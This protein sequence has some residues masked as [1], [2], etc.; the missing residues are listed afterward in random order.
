M[1]QPAF[2]KKQQITFNSEEEYYEFLGFL[3][4]ND[5]TTKLVWEENNEQGAWTEEGRILFFVNQPATLRANL[6]HTAGNYNI[7]FRVN[8]NDFIEDIRTNHSFVL[9]ETQN[10]AIIRNTIPNQF[11]ASFDGGLHL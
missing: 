7:V 2:G 10:T 11:L 3:S 4:K 5:G 8:C 1:Y 9:G 6:L